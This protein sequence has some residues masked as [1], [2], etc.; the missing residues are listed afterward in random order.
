M[1]VAM[2]AAL[3]ACETVDC[4]VELMVSKKVEQMVV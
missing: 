4:L 1:T 3:K 2:K